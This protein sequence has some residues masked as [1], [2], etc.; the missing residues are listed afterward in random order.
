MMLL[1]TELRKLPGYQ[2]FDALAKSKVAMPD[3]QIAEFGQ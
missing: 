2:L 3:R 1:S